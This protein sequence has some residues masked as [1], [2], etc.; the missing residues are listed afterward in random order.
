MSG[1][2][3][4][5]LPPG[6]AA[7]A[8]QPVQEVKRDP[9]VRLLRFLAKLIIYHLMWRF[10][11][12]AG[13]WA[14]RR[15]WR[16]RDLHAPWWTACGLYL[17]VAIADVTGIPWWVNA[18]WTT[19]STALV[20]LA[21]R[22]HH[23]L[24]V[25]VTAVTAVTATA[26]VWILLASV[27]GVLHVAAYSG[28]ALGV[29]ALA[30]AWG[31]STD[32]RKWRSVRLRVRVLAK[33]LPIVLA[34]LGFAG[35][36]V[37]GRISVSGTGRVEIPLRLPVNVTRVK[38]DKPA[39][40]TEIESG[41]HWPAGSIREVIQDPKHTS[42]ARV[43][44]IWHEGKIEARTVKFAPPKVPSSI[45]E[46]AWVGVDD[47]GRD[48]YIAQ[49]LPKHGM[50]R[51]VYAGEPG[52]AKSNL[53]RL[54]A[55]MRAHCEDVLLWIID[56]KNDGLTY[57]PLLPRLDRPIATTW[58]AATRILE[59]AAA[60]IPL[61][62]RQL[63]PEDNQL[64]PVS[65]KRPAILI[66][67]DEIAELLGK[68]A[69][70]ARP[71]EAARKVGS[72]GRALGIGWETASQYLSQSSMDPDLLPFCNRRYSGRV[73]KQ[74]D[75]QHVLKNWNRLDTTLL[76]TGVFY[77]QQSGSSAT[78]LLYT[79][80]VTDEMLAEA[81]VKTAHVAA[82]LEEST[83][84]GLPHYP[85]RWADL[86][87]HLLRFCTKEQEALVYQAR[88]RRKAAGLQKAAGGAKVA[89][90]G[91]APLRLVVSERVEVPDDL[92][93]LL[94]QIGDDHLRALVKV[95]LSP[96]EI[97]TRDS[98]AAVAPHRRRAWA[99]LRRGVWRKRGLLEQP[100]HG[101]WRRAV[102]KTDLIYGALEAEEDIRAGRTD[103]G[104]GPHTDPLDTSA[105]LDIRPDSLSPHREDSQIGP[106]RGSGPG[107][108]GPAPPDL[109]DHTQ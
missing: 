81:A 1:K 6:P 24:P 17:Y 77:C 3:P 40:R 104:E 39:A 92:E 51:G 70:N 78:T 79:P 102:G 55:W 99:S 93:S 5:A 23:V 4:A 101:K 14:A 61:R 66:I 57:A 52:S 75:A 35:V 11:R 10:V 100:A 74:S 103:G 9:L 33:T 29:L 7:N 56:L 98:N 106:Q 86:P 38:L 48:V 58:E 82:K 43:L 15:M 91:D 41:M 88:A 96:G 13:L 64:F 84:A 72:Q 94:S 22:R 62:G 20:H 60:A 8:P 97:T 32:A 49:Y 36:V 50:T 42:S 68:K 87:D 18:M 71:I 53:Q 95:H 37:A 45:L 44:L 12:A 46:A 27:I 85:D 73:A 89:A 76:P 26:G 47:D 105:Y 16:H 83:A 59:D 90:A 28:W 30:I 54:I 65:S 67:G 69:A 2:R 63:R 107:G 31:F 109:G 21:L 80:E 108:G 34:E 25:S 19:A